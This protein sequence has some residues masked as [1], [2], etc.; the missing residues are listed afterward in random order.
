MFHDVA[1]DEDRTVEWRGRVVG[2]GTGR[3]LRVARTRTEIMETADSEVSFGF[4]QV[5]SVAVYVEYHGLSL[6][7]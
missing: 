6:A 3:L 1:D 2:N 5:G 4:G 7:V